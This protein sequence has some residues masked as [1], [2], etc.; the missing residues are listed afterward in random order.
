MSKR[1]MP[2]I[3]LLKYYEGPNNNTNIKAHRMKFSCKSRR[4]WSFR[5]FCTVYNA[6]LSLSRRKA[7]VWRGVG[8]ESF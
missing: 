4:R 1:E 8:V 5:V 2:I 6:I 7:S 3:R